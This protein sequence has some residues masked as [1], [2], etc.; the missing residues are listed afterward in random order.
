MDE[1][2]ASLDISRH[3]LAAE[4]AL[5]KAQAGG[6]VLAASH[7]INWLLALCTRLICLKEGRL[8]WEG[9]PEESKEPLE[10]A[11]GISLTWLETEDGPQAI[12]TRP[13]RSGR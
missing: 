7:D 3:S 10:E 6:G 12:P 4:L 5:E 8:F 11:L 2:T 1:P 9:T 13:R